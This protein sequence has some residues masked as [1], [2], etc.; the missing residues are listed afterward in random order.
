MSLEQR[1]AGGGLSARIRRR[2]YSCWGQYL[3]ALSLALACSKADTFSV[4]AADAEVAVDA[5]QCYDE[6]HDGFYST[7]NCGTPLDCQDNDSTIFPGGLELCD[8]K[9]NNCNLEKDEG[10][11]IDL[12]EDNDKDGFGNPEKTKLGCYLSGMDPDIDEESYVPNNDDCNDDDFMVNPAALEICDGK[13]NNCQEGIDEGLLSVFYLDADDDGKGNPNNYL[14]ACPLPLGYVSDNT[15]CDDTDADL[16]QLINMYLDADFDGYGSSPVSICIGSF[17]PPGYSLNGLDCDDSIM[18]VHP[19]ALEVCDEHDNDC[20]PLTI[21]GSGETPPFNAVQQG[22]CTGSLKGCV[23]GNWIDNYNG[24]ADYEIVETLCD[25]LNNDCDEETDEGLM[26][27]L[28]FDSDNDS[29]GNSNNSLMSCALSWGNYVLMGG[30]CDDANELIFPEAVELCDGLNNDCDDLIDEE[31]IAPS[32]PC[33]SGTGQC[34]GLGL[35]YKIC[36]GLAS[37]SEQYFNCDAVEG[38]PSEEIADGIDNDCN[39]I[40]DDVPPITCGIIDDFNR[41]DQDGLGNNAYGHPWVQT[42]TLDDWDIEGDTAVTSYTGG[43]GTNPKASSET[44]YK[45]MFNILLRFKLSE[46]NE[47]G[48]GGAFIFHVNSSLEAPNGL[49]AYI[50]VANSSTHYLANSEVGDSVMGNLPLQPN[51]FYLLR[52]AYDGST[53]GL[54]L[55]EDGTAEPGEPLLSASTPNVSPAKGYVIITGDEDWSEQET[56]ILDYIVD[57]SESCN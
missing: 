36:Q 49:A 42:G 57:E 46:V 38:E 37:W 22:V 2:V 6:D 40:I 45:S 33:S 14:E 52:F 17:V 30:D 7:V 32:Q 10:V 8:Y 39:G 56:I 23:N 28:Y 55:W 3:A 34:Q 31:L 9:D 48:N 19:G 29:F 4:P 18:T 43:S 13:D 11:Q 47:V 24:I 50:A 1:V 27:T 5:Q 16:W 20:D 54:K 25:S 12:Y 21:D 53:L 44:G 15:D 26:N 41:Q 51:T 35:E